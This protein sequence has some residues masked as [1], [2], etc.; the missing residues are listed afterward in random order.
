MSFGAVLGKIGH[1]IV[2]ATQV[3]QIAA[4]LIEMVPGVGG[5]FGIVLNV[6]VAVEQAI[7]NSGMGPAKKAAATTLITAAVPTINQDA[8]SKAIDDLVTALNS[9]QKAQA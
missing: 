7:P 5:L 4:P 8:L 3:A 9:T 1:V 6:V 2:G